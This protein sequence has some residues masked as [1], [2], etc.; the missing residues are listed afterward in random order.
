MLRNRCYRLILELLQRN[1]T[2]D[3]NHEYTLTRDE[4]IQSL[5]RLKMVTSP[6]VAGLVFNGLDK[7]EDGIV[8]FD[9]LPEISPSQ[10]SHLEETKLKAVFRMLDA[11]GSGFIELKEFCQ[12]MKSNDFMLSKKEFG[13]LFSVIDQNGNSKVTYD[14]FKTFMSD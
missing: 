6:E 14:E 7:N 9:E 1:L 8:Y 10:K 11:D 2:V 3:E 4:F 13:K 5:V 12:V